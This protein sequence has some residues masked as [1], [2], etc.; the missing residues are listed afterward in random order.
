MH[1]SVSQ[2]PTIGNCSV[3]LYA[4]SSQDAPERVVGTATCA[5]EAEDEDGNQIELA[6][7]WVG[8]GLDFSRRDKGITKLEVNWQAEY[9]NTQLLPTR[10][11]ANVFF[12]ANAPVPIGITA[13]SFTIDFGGTWTYSSAEIND[14]RSYIGFAISVCFLPCDVTQSAVMQQ[15]VICPSVCPSTTSSGMFFTQVGILRK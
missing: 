12:I 4:K 7:V 15:N 3:K 9:T 8:A 2:Q 1:V 10:P 13:G 6:P 11:S 14:S 5:A